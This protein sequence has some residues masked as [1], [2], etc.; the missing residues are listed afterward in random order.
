VTVVM[1]RSEEHLEVWEKKREE[2]KESGVRY[3][4][5]SYVDVH[6]ITKAKAVPIDHFTGMMR[7][8]ELFTGA[9]IEGLGQEPSDDELSLWPDVEAITVLPWDPTIAWA[10]GSLHYHGEPWPMDSRTVLKRQ[11]E[12]AAAKG[13]RPSSI[14]SKERTA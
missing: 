14:L 7:G 1:Q 11:V 6:G 12:R 5:S 10:P 2:L 8:S 13:S 3:C 9:A 4:L